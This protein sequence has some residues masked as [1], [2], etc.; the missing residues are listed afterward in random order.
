[1]DDLHTLL[2]ATFGHADFRAGQEPV[3]RSVAEGHDCLV[4]M[5]TGAGKSLCYQLP[6][7]ARGGTTLVVSPLIALM[8]DQVDALQAKGVAATCI[9]SSIGPGERR[10]RIEAMIAGDW[11]IVYVA[12]ER[13]TPRF[14]Q[15]LSQVDLRLLAIDE[16]HCISEW[17]HD[18]RPDY[19]RLGRVR[20]ALGC[21]PTV[22]LTATAT[23]EVQRDIVRQVG[24][25]R[26][27]RF[28]TGFDRKNLSFEVHECAAAEQK[29][30]L[31]RQL[32]SP[33]PALVYCATRRN[34]ERAARFLRDAG[35][36]AGMYH[37]GLPHQDRAQV[38]EAF[39]AGRL[40]VVV[41]TNAFGM[42]VDKADIRCIVHYDIPGTVEAYYQE[43][44]RAGRDGEPAR[45]VL[46]F[47]PSDRRIQE[48]FVRMAHPPADT[49]R[50]VYSELLASWS[51]ASGG[52]LVD[53]PRDRLAAA[54]PADS[55]GESAVFSCLR[56]LE[57]QGWLRRVP[58]RERAGTVKLLAR[59]PRPPRG[60][61]GRVYQLVEQQLG[62]HPDE[63][64]QVQPWRLCR[65]LG[66]EREQLLAAL[67][68]LESR[69]LLSYS[70]PHQVG[71]V[72]LLRPEQALSLDEQALVERRSFD[73]QKLERM[74]GY[75]DAAC[76]RHYLLSYFG[77][78]PAYQ[79]CGSCDAC[80]SG[81]R[82]GQ[83]AAPLQDWQLRV[84][85]QVLGCVGSLR[86]SYSLSMLARVLSGSQERNIRAMRLDR[87]P[88]YGV[89]GSWSAT[90]VQSLLDA[91][92]RAGALERSFV[93][94]QVGGRERTYG[95]L[96]LSSSGQRV[97]QGGDPDF[98]VAFPAGASRAAERAL[99]QQRSRHSRQREQPTATGPRVSHDL[100]SYLREVRRQLAQAGEVPAYVVASNRTL[101]EIAAHRPVTREAMLAVHGMGP[102]RFRRYGHALLDALQAWGGG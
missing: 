46:L 73:L 81:R 84:L 3:V 20:E 2:K 98:Q 37:G 78:K 77:E 44:G 55:G 4:V 95:V 15:Q 34:V 76:R 43:V 41:A 38:Q 14:L 40:P 63:S 32:T 61:V 47:H 36:Q 45:A 89:L 92:V 10:A 66:V 80:R 75:V 6:A 93:T 91:L 88:S 59:P 7:L 56:V 22:A 79:R 57:R 68:G 50:T 53:A 42:G 70:A 12:P 25:S 65:E 8:K 1:M 21:P 99:Q 86:E 71:A 54:L 48:F 100:L 97:A 82:A 31:L 27:R 72:E 30:A 49:V 94:R 90:E 18:F 26:C 85:R 74:I 96:S 29:L 60:L 17:G 19:L 62:A 11:A 64:W 39:M 5:P 35:V 102:E 58:P 101:Q 9:N 69:G 67:R 52:N 28:V 87:S 83:Q 13:F 23:P 33:G 51:A 24:F 16:A